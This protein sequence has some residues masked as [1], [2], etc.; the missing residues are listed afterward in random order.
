MSDELRHRLRRVDMTPP[1]IQGA[2]AAMMK[3]YD[4]S[5]VTAVNEWRNA[6]Q[7]AKDDQILPLLYVSNEVLQTSKRNRGNKFLEAFSP[8]LGRALVFMAQKLPAE[9]T[10]KIRR[11]IKIWGDRRVFSV[12]YVN[13]LLVGLEPYRP[14]NRQ[15]QQQQAITHPSS[16]PEQEDATFSPAATTTS[17]HSATTPTHSPSKQPEE[18]P[19]T[20]DEQEEGDSS[21]DSDDDI[22]DIL[23][24]HDPTGKKNNQDE[25]DD[26]FGED[27]E[28]QT[29]DIEIDVDAAAVQ[30]SNNTNNNGSSTGVRRRGSSFRQGATNKRRRS[31]ASSHQAQSSSSRVLSAS[32]LLDVW[33]Q[34][35]EHQQKYEL[36]QQ[37]VARIQDSLKHKQPPSDDLANLV[38]DELQQA[39]QQNRLDRRN[40]QQQRRILHRL[41]NER[42]ALS[43]EA[44]RYLPWLEQ[45]LA[46][47]AQDLAFCD[48]LEAKLIQFQPVHAQL[49]R[50]RDVLRRE[51]QVRLAQQAEAERQ[52]R[53]AEENERFRR[54]ALAKETEAKPGMVWNP[55]TR[56][57]QALNTDE[58]WRD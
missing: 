28:R 49:Q 27:S 30:N 53:E 41:A 48:T 35:Q 33:N 1:A 23:E 10:E 20:R 12:R 52:R 14:G 43:L 36:A 34:L 17:D 21:A 56:E 2:A 39:V 13:E 7:T 19:T 44:A 55:T 42:R 38:G 6:L 26:L 22:M 29:L 57:Y 47:D 58:S 15:A 25:D 45:A 16:D 5:A 9:M 3:H 37:A 54:A 4:R 18:T 46:H 8:V 51:D 31:S 32:N 24:A 40:L 11:T 50:T